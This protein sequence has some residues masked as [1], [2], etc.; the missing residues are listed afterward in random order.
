M[1]AD[2]K[3][4]AEQ[5]GVSKTTVHRALANAGRISPET[6]EKILRVAAELDYR[7]NNLAR[8]L[9]SQKSATVGLVVI[10]LTNSFYATILEGVESVATES[11]YSVLI[12]RTLG[13]PAREVQHLDVLRE[14]RA[15][16]MII[17][18]ASPTQN[19]EY[20]RKLRSSG[21]PFVF[22][23]RYL[24]SV[25]SD[26]VMT[27]SFLGA[28][29]A[30]R[31]LISLGRKKVGF[32][33]VPGAE[34]LSTSITERIRGLTTALVEAGLEPPAMIGAGVPSMTPQE[35]FAVASIRKFFEDGNRVDAVLGGNDD[36]AIGIIKG[37]QEM[38]IAVPDD[39]SVV[40]FDDL[41]IAPYVQPA[42]TTVRQP[43]REMGEEALRL[44]LE[45]MSADP[46]TPFKHVLLLPELVVRE[47]CG[48][49]SKDKN[50]NDT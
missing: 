2:M 28:Y 23:D 41:D 46:N 8:G 49:K 20:Y 50:P 7:P 25:D 19:V 3:T 35:G 24:P 32:A 16:G 30:G 15:D 45:R 38:G 26:Y 34:M 43:A 9:R 17:A 13:S 22:I 14:K 31:H 48:A 5:V 12:A 42:L 33:G 10:G 44:L 47:S 18:P 6:R 27:D 21:I 39:V 4:I 37:L 40:G 29:M 11:G 36:T 1:P